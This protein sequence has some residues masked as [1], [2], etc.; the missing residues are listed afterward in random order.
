MNWLFKVSILFA[1][2]TS[3]CVV[4]AEKR[5]FFT[6][7]ERIRLTCIRHDKRGNNILSALES[8]RE[9]Q[10][11]VCRPTTYKHREKHAEQIIIEV[12]V[13]S[14]SKQ[15]LWKFTPKRKP[16]K[17]PKPGYILLL[18]VALLLVALPSSL[19]MP[20]PRNIKPF[21]HKFPRECQVCPLAHC[22]SRNVLLSQSHP[23]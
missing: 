1:L 13:I 8:H 22:Q 12:V 14:I 18:V 7:H 11:E 23:F 2:F 17:P 10:A 6:T 5:Y 9:K 16:W 4:E 3:F 15:Q 21:A 19:A 20:P